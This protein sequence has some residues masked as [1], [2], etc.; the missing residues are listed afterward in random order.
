M[1]HKLEPFLGRF[2]PAAATAWSPRLPAA[3]AAC[4]HSSSRKHTVIAPPILT[5][6][7]SAL[8]VK[9]C[10]GPESRLSWRQ[11]QCWLARVV[12]RALGYTD[13]T[14]AGEQ[15]VAARDNNHCSWASHDCCVLRCCNNKHAEVESITD[16]STSEAYSSLPTA[17]TIDHL[18]G[19]CGSD[20]GNARGLL[21]FP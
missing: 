9:W 13:V 4:T 14:E 12:L 11:A 3:V 6:L 18:V 5:V 17:I 20:D 16:P 1:A 10:C 8:V 19:S 7:S 15:G 21:L 2:Q